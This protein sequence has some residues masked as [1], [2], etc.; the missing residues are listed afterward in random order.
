VHLSKPASKNILLRFLE[1]KRLGLARR[2][3]MFQ[4]LS[5]CA[6]WALSAL[7]KNI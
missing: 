4:E 7:P 3:E 6:Y 1:Y 5:R 2:S